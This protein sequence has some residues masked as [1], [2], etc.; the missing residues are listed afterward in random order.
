MLFFLF[1]LMIRRPPIST[2]T[3][4]LFPYTTLF[5]SR[6]GGADQDQADDVRDAER[7]G[8]ARGLAL[9][10]RKLAVDQEDRHRHADGDQHAEHQIQPHAAHAEPA[11]L[12]NHPDENRRSEEHKSELQ[13]IMRSSYAVFCFKKK[14]T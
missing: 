13:S 12:Q 3:D 11:C 7:P 1:F 14:T 5:R 6:A 10:Q 2:R 9:M 4:T 8:A